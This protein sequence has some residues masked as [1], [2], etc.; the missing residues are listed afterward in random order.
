MDFSASGA[1]VDRLSTDLGYCLFTASVLF[2]FNSRLP[3]QELSSDAKERFALCKEWLKKLSGT[4]PSASAH[5]QLLDGFA[6]VGE[7]E[8]EGDLNDVGDEQMKDGTGDSAGKG[9]SVSDRRKSNT[10]P[11]GV[12]A[13]WQHQ[14]AQQDQS[15]SL[16]VPN[17]ST[18]PTNPNESLFSANSRN[19]MSNPFGSREA[20]EQK[21]QLIDYYANNSLHRGNGFPGSSQFFGNGDE[22]VNG[23]NSNLGQMGGNMMNTGWGFDAPASIFDIEVSY[24]A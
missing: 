20:Q 12:I 17:P 4:W 16:G 21:Q 14:Q 3:H 7:G 19:S 9:A 15:Q 11:N 10:D 22:S 18:K 13:A 6:T 1:P 8:N 2:F 23:Q 5:K 24:C